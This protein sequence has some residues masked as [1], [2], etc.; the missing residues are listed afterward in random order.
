MM[1]KAIGVALFFSMLGATALA[2]PPASGGGGPRTFSP[3]PP[4]QM[5]LPAQRIAPPMRTEPPRM[6][7]PQNHDAQPER[8][9]APPQ[10]A[11][12]TNDLTPYQRAA[13]NCLTPENVS[14]A[15][16]FANGLCS[17]VH[18]SFHNFDGTL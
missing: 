13:H 4:M 15:F 12:R 10:N 2:N 17:T 9:S 1:K 3:S 18:P 6:P 16:N 8:I 7:L 11:V 14:V 5:S